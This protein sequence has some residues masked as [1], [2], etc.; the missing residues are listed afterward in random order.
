MSGFEPLLLS[1]AGTAV[2]AIGSI[3]QGRAGAAADTYNA[4]AAQVEAQAKETAQ[5]ADAARHI[6]AQRAAIGKSGASFVGTPILALAE[7]ASQAEID[8]LNTRYTGE[9]QADLYKASASNRRTQGMIGAGASLL[10]GA[11]KLWR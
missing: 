4:Q 1:A 10:S 8:A 7:S 9:R 3:A 5:R 2:S 6:G 11:G